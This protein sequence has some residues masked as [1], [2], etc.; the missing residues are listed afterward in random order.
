MHVS[1]SGS[2][3][4]SL[5]LIAKVG[6]SIF[7]VLG[8]DNV[9]K[10]RNMRKLFAAFVAGLFL[11]AGISPVALAQMPSLPAPNPQFQIPV[12]ES[13][14]YAV[15]WRVFPAGT[16][17][18]H[19]R[20]QGNNVHV[21]GTAASIGTVNLLFPVSDRYDSV[22]DRLSGCSFEYRKQIQEGHRRISGLMQLD[23]AHHLQK[24]SEKNLVSGTYKE[25]TSPIPAC[26][27]DVLSAIFY[28]GSQPLQVGHDL[29]FPL[30]DGGHVVPVTV[31]VEA[32]ESVITP[33][34]TFAAIRV[35]PTADAGVVK[36]RGNIWIWYTDDAR[37]LPVQVRAHLFWGTITMR[38][39]RIDHP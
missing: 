3:H 22:F 4:I 1:C 9:T 27:T 31:K 17:T 16:A 18:F 7:S 29:H 24:I 39:T 33:A 20:A 12:D 25:Q 14:T 6:N 35:Q 11:L 28:V 32:K 13:L 34:G 36:N 15:D 26:V 23:Y 21:V 37:H 30:A 2:P 19:L 5:V 10:K 38:L 8:E